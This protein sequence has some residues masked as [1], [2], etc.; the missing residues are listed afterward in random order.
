VAGCGG[1]YLG[2]GY[3]VVEGRKK[4]NPEMGTMTLQY[5]TKKARKGYTYGR[6]R[7]YDGLKEKYRLVTQCL[8]GP[9]GGN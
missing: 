6:L 1:Y 9:W 4:N 7:G 8:P 3:A 5:I 2:P